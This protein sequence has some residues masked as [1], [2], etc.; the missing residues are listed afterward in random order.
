MQFGLGFNN[1]AS[2]I[3]FNQEYVKPHSTKEPLKL[4]SFNR[5]ESDIN[6]PTQMVHDGYTSSLEKRLLRSKAANGTSG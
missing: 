1:S 2:F 3:S 6:I 5:M 4:N